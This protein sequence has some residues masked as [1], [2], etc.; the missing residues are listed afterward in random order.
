MVSS[1]ASR[2]FRNGRVYIVDE[3][4]SWAGAVA[5]GNGRIIYVG[6]EAGLEAYIGPETEVTDLD[7]RMMLPGFFDSHVHLAS[8]GLQ[9]LD[10]NL[11]GIKEPAD[12]LAAIRTYIEEEGPD[13]SGWIR[14]SGWDSAFIQAPNKRWLDELAPDHPVFLNCMDGHSA[15]V[16]SAA[17]E[18]AGITDDTL[19]P[20]AGRIERDPETGEA[21]G[22]LMD[23]AAQLVKDVM[24]DVGLD[25]QIAGLK[26]GISLA[27]SFGITSV[28]EPGLDAGMIAPYVVL[29]DRGELNIRL[30]AGLSPN[31]WQPGT[32]DDRIYDCVLSRDQFR[33]DRIDVDSVKVYIDGVLEYGSAVLLE[34]YLIEEWNEEAV[35]FYTQDQLDEYV[36]WLDSQGIQVHTHS[37]GDRGTRMV[38][39]AYETARRINGEA[40]NR[41]HICHLQMID[42]DD[43]ARFAELNVMANFQPFWAQEDV[44][45]QWYREILGPGRTDRTHFLLGSVHRSGGRLVGGSDWFV[46]SLN[47]LD[48]ISV[49]VRRMD[50]E[51]DEGPAFNADECVDL[52]TMIAAYTINGAYA[53]H[54]E[55]DLGSIEVGKLADLIVLDLNLFEIPEAAIAKARVDL[56]I[57]EGTEVYRRDGLVER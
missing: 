39:D 42:P 16:N 22:W 11:A 13:A 9:E 49:G 15:W 31:N 45:K 20:R 35:P 2:V 56:T 46:T 55:N 7:G 17:L 21:T 30:R 12:V 40:D 28:I 32:F 38:L 4:R 36:T 34:P 53:S 10:C 6:D 54:R 26:A 29:A 19:D 43:V 25:R 41:H 8:G 52:D 3:L 48:A 23:Y 24:P 57:L 33:R 50:P 37:I 47:P 5:V 44:H 14:G 18:L 1:I 27:H 51:L